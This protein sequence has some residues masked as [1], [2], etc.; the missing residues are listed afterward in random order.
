MTGFVEILQ[1][2][3][4]NLKLKMCDT[5]KFKRA[6]DKSA[7]REYNG[8]VNSKGAADMVSVALFFGLSANSIHK[9]VYEVSGLL[10]PFDSYAV[11]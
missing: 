4:A 11:S 2:F 10:Q 7:K 5:S 1:L 8:I 3:S 6:I 9:G